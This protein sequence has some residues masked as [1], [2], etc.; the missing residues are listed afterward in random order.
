MYCSNGFELVGIA[1]HYVFDLG[2]RYT[3][4]WSDYLDRLSLL[5]LLDLL[6]VLLGL[7]VKFFNDLVLDFLLALIIKAKTSTLLGIVTTTLAA[8]LFLLS[9][10]CL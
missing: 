4:H 7:V 9:F 2:L 10:L 1:K 8:G 6:F 3:M 5:L